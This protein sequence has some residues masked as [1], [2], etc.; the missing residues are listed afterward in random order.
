M[1]VCVI[2]CVCDILYLYVKE[3]ETHDNDRQMTNHLPCFVHISETHHRLRERERGQGKE[4]EKQRNST[5]CAGFISA[6]IASGAA[7]ASIAHVAIALQL[8]YA[9]DRRCC[10][11][12]RVH[13]CMHKNMSNTMQKPQ[14][15]RLC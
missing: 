13:T 6:S 7:G 14:T 11:T 3:R 9:A 2:V 5:T 12:L 8:K 15:A 10:A 1:C 4:G